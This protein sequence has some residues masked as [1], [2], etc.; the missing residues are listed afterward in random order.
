VV[1]AG[2]PSWFIKAIAA[3]MAALQ[4]FFR[5]SQIAA[6]YD[7]FTVVAVTVFHQSGF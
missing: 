7:P 3:T 5:N 4:A 2:H 1:R 6:L